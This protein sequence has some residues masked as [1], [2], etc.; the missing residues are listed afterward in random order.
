K[1]STA[2]VAFWIVAGLVKIYWPNP[3]ASRVVITLA[4]PGDFV[5][6]ADL[7]ESNGRRVQAFEAKAA[8][9]A[10]LALFTRE[11]VVRT[12]QGMDSV[13]LVSVIETLNTSWSLAAASF[14]R[15]FGLG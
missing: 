13:G 15:F 2:D 5:G 7:I 9:K 12:L 3:D 10:T 11:H 1:G 8:T 6:M 14:V 4:G